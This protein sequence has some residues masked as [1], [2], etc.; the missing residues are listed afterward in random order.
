VWAGLGLTD[1]TDGHAPSL[2]YAKASHIQ[3]VLSG[4][5]VPDLYSLVSAEEQCE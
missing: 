4:V 2:N 3:D 1:E 5:C